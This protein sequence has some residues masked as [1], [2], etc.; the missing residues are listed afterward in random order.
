MERWN[1]VKSY[2]LH[3]HISTFALFLVFCLGGVLTF[4]NYYQASQLIR[5]A[6]SDVFEQSRQKIELDFQRSYAPIAQTVH[7]LTKTPLVSATTFEQRMVQL[8]LLITALQDQ[9]ELAALEVAYQNGDYFIVRVIND[10]HMRDV[11]EAPKDAAFLVDNIQYENAGRGIERVFLNAD[12]VQVGSTQLMPTQYDPRLRDWY[13]QAANANAEGRLTEPYLYFFIRKVGVTYSQSSPDGNAVVAGDIALDVLSASVQEQKITPGSHLLILDKTRGVLAYNRRPDPVYSATDERVRL[14][15][16]NDLQ[17]P[18][19]ELAATRLDGTEK[20]FEL[21]YQDQTWQGSLKLLAPIPQAQFQLLLLTPEQELLAEAYDIRRY[22][23]LIAFVL[24]LM[25]LPLTWWIARRVTLALQRLVWQS[26]E[27]QR[28]HLGYQIENRSRIKEIV[29]LATAMGVMQQTL[30]VFI[31]QLEQLNQQRHPDGL[32]ELLTKDLQQI[33]GYEG[34]LLYRPRD[35]QHMYLAGT[36]YKTIPSAA[37]LPVQIPLVLD[38]VIARAID[39]H[40][41]QCADLRTEDPLVFGA[42]SNQFADELR[43]TAVP[44]ISGH[45]RGVLV[46]LEKHS[47]SRDQQRAFVE[48]LAGFAAHCLEHAD[49]EKRVTDSASS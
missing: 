34:V 13:T 11:F 10:Q 45:I 23:T 39:M 27:I 9:P 14:L 29:E 20:Q 43:L 30:R 48:A 40:S 36:G 47:D 6:A 4:Y 18:L 21:T 2:P 3:I 22:S 17:Q 26:Q 46:L 41:S 33:T 7:L 31:R 49:H 24:L 28:F 12:S 32:T 38:S 16:I 35:K 8:P 5:S 37:N 19:L 42:L 25:F 15:H 1:R 44:L